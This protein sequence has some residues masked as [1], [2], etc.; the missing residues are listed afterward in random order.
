MQNY[1]GLEKLQNICCLQIS[2]A[3][4]KNLEEFDYPGKVIKH[5]TI[6][7]KMYKS[8]MFRQDLLRVKVR[9]VYG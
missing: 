5:W 2:S 3:A 1:I 4:L 6:Y 9:G 8:P 7:K